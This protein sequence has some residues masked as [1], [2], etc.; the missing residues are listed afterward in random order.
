MVNGRR[1]DPCGR[2]SGSLPLLSPNAQRLSPVVRR[3]DMNRITRLLL[4][5]VFALVG[6]SAGP[7]G[8]ASPYGWVRPDGRPVV[9]NNSQPISYS[10]DQGPLGRLSNAD[11][12]T[13]VQAAFQ[14][15]QSVGT[16]SISFAPAAPLPQDITGANVMAFLNNLPAGV[17]PI[18][19]DSH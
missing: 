3:N 17:T 1:G 18:L 16:P 12:V 6:T 8:A 7:V 9:W 19:F 4:L 10:V 11:A 2:P 13:L 5:C 15:W 14:R